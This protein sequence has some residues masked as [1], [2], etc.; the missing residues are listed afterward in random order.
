[1]DEYGIELG[2]EYTDTLTGFVGKA[3]ARH[4]FV[5]G[6]TRVTLQR[7]DQ[8][9]GDIKSSRSTPR[10]SCA[11]RSRRRR[12]RPSAPAGQRA[13]WPRRVV[14][15]QRSRQE[16]GRR[17]TQWRVRAGERAS[18]PSGSGWRTSVVLPRCPL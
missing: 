16:V 12:S 15:E 11:R 8:T 2:E 6:C 17:S 5:H 3:I 18:S 7:L 4:E 1:M 13:T 14:G 10:R 9:T